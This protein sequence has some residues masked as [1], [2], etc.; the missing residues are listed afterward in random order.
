[1]KSADTQAR[2]VLMVDD[3]PGI[4]QGAVS[5]LKGA[6]IQQVDTLEDSRRV[7]PFL[8]ST[9]VSILILDLFMPHV[10]GMEL[11]P[12]IRQKFPEITIIVMTASMDLE[13]AVACM[14]EGAFDYLVKPV[15]EERLIS[16]VKKALE[17]H[18]LR[19]QVLSLKHSFLTSQAASGP[20]FNAIITRCHKMA[21][22]FRYVTATAR[23]SEPILITGE[24]GVGKEL[25]AQAVHLAS[26]RKGK[27]ITI[28]AAGLDDTVFTDTLFGHKKGA[29]TGADRPREGLIAQANRGTLFLDEIGDL[30]ESSQLKLL[31]LLQERNYYPLGSDLPR[32]TDARIV[33]ATNRNLEKRIADGK[34]RA[35]FYYRLS[36]HEITIP[37]LRER[38]E[39]IPLLT[40]HFFKEAARSMDKAVPTPP[41]ELFLLLMAYEFPG[42]VRELRALVYD[43]V[44]QH[45]S[46]MISMQS[47]RKIIDRTQ[48]APALERVATSQIDQESL[49]CPLIQFPGRCPT[50]KEAEWAVIHEALQ[51]ADSNQTIAANLLGL[52]RQALNRRLSRNTS[53]SSS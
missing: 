20:V 46:R 30:S 51:R 16:S 14:K 28:N 19:Q 15:E 8:E 35:D 6:G 17:I 4:L 1:M 3:E 39:D 22:I 26:G 42:N 48:S 7:I 43:A 2:S 53:T 5:I 24:T 18:S 49:T 27:F 40:T 29:Y 44:A 23:T 45:E 13:T 38:K 10:S 36:V 37:P 25:F 34:F 32:E 12:E 52:S 41:E 21:A 11:L 9:M 31:R 33:L 50:L 47:F